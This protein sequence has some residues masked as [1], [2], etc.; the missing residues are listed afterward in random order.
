[1]QRRRAGSL[2]SSVVIIGCLWERARSLASL[3][4][5]CSMVKQVPLSPM[6]RNRLGTN[7][8]LALV[9]IVW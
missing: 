1:M 9:G 8:V 3:S 2:N 7:F 5:E 4:N 6:A